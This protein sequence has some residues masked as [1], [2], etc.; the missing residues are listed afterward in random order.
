MILPAG[1]FSRQKVGRMLGVDLAPARQ[2]NV[3][4]NE[5]DTIPVVVA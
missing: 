4:D 3:D 1:L 5:E 2:V